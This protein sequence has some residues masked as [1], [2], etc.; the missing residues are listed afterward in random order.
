M[1]GD[2]KL[3]QPQRFQQIVADEL[4][5]SAQSGCMQAHGEL[6]AMFSPAVL[7]LARGFCKNQSTAEDIV[8]NTFVKLIDKVG[9]FQFRAPFGMWLRQVAVT[10]SLM[11]L[12][13]QKKHNWVSTDEFP[14]LDQSVD[15][16]DESF[17]SDDFIDNHSDKQELSQLLNELPEHVRLILWLKEVEAY[18]H[19][20]IAEFVG[21]TP[22]YSKSV[23]ARTY[24]QLRAKAKLNQGFNKPH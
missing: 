23:V 5:H 18:T 16:A 13:K 9:T 17:I 8:H 7:T 12:R 2:T 24:S 1:Q 4:V 3:T 22:S 15:V 21:K 20:E 6:Y 19:A 14:L 10:E 11:Y